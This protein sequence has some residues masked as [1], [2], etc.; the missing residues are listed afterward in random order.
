MKVSPDSA[1]D[2]IA[3]LLKRRGVARVFALCGGHIMPIWMRLDAEG[4]RIIDVRDERAA[5]HM[6]QAHAEL[7]GELGVALVTAGPGMTNAITGI[8]N[9]HVSRAPV[10]VISGG[11]P[12]PQENRG[13]LQDMDHTQLVRSITRYART[14]REPSLVLQELDEAISRAFGDGGEPGPVFIDFPVDTLRGLVPK[15]M[16]LEEH[17]APKPRAATR[18]DPVEVEKA[19]ELLWSAR[20]VLVISGR[21]ARGAGPELIGLLDRLGAVY[22]DTGESRGLVPDDHPSVVGAMRGA[23]M[24]DADVV[25]TV[26]RKL[27]F[28]LA[29]GSPAVFKD[30]KF[31]RISDTA[32]ELR[33]NRRGAAEILAS[34][35]ESLRAMVALAGNRE[36]AVDRQWAGKLRAAHQERA[37]KLKQSMAA[38]PAGADGRLHPNRVLSAL[39]EA[40]GNDAVVI[41]DG[42]DFLSFAR[43]GLSAPMMLDPGPFGCIG[44]GVPYGIAASLAFPDKPVVVATGDGAFGFNAIEVDTAV[45]HKAPVLIV[46]ANN[47]A[48]QIEVHDQ[49]VTHGKV[50]GTRL[51]FADHAAMARA[52][53]MHAERVETAEQ[54]GPAIKRAL[55]NRPALLD[56]V[57][58]PEAVSSDAK[59]GLAWVPD[60]QPLA[61]WDEAERKWRGT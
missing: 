32:S 15:A 5:V 46:V 21:G 51:Q 3:R 16:Q 1:A 43:V 40:I 20:R 6:A 41:T 13:G 52:F 42:G 23:V 39:Q 26:G 24:G 14:V 53:G 19:V 45:R 17:L 7:T 34:P 10:L 37:A 56:M 55:A 47:G 27:D 31:V 61:A 54:L 36:S 22:L 12:R 11:N 2:L 35:A 25:L 30:A 48:W 58:T 57:V 59:T 8:A 29:Y 50:V 9:A 49:T 44:I 60:L 33:D 28:Q 4:I 18:P 38:A